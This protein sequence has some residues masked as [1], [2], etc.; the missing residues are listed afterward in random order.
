M[1]FHSNLISDSLLI[2][3]TVSLLKFHGGTLPATQIADEVLRMSNLDEDFA[4]TLMNDLVGKDSRLRLN[5]TSIELALPDFHS[6]ILSETDFIVFDTETTGAKPPNARM[7]EIGAFKVKGGK[8]VDKFETLLNP[9]IPIPPFI[10]SLTGISDEMVKTAPRFFEVAPDLLDF[11]GDAVLVAHN[12]QFDM[13]FLNF[14]IGRVFT[15][16]KLIN[17][18]LCTVRLSRRLVPNL[19]NYKL[20]TVAESFGIEIQNRHRAAG[21]AIATAEVFINLLNIVNDYGFLDVGS[22]VKVQNTKINK[23]RRAFTSS[24]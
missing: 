6:K 7:T 4:V 12:S 1:R 18:D 10:T 8:I 14:E 16:R 19:R 20:H 3:E 23:H 11:I 24:T 17:A 21:D 9:L 15:G 13:G 22:L 2:S 5:G